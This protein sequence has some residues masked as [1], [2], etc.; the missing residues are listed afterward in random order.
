LGICGFVNCGQP[1]FL[2]G[3]LS[4]QFSFAGASAAF[5]GDWGCCPSGAEAT[6]SCCAGF[7]APG[8]RDVCNDDGLCAAT[9]GGW[10]ILVSSRWPNGHHR[11]PVSAATSCCELQAMRIM[12]TSAREMGR[13][14]SMPPK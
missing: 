13:M 9:P 10:A 1:I 4:I 3:E 8:R 12:P 14:A 5:S 11:E 7:S 2:F 6:D